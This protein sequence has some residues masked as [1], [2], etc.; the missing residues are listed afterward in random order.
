MWVAAEPEGGGLWESPPG[1]THTARVPC[2]RR[3]SLAP[4]FPSPSHP[5][6]QEERP[7]EEAI[8][9]TELRFG[10]LTCKYASSSGEGGS[11][12][13]LTQPEMVRCYHGFW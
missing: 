3:G 7:A 13:L 5:R 4:Y 8:N 10:Q 9:S 1:G 2:L 6:P 12:F 11:G